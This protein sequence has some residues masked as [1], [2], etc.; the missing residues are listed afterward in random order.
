M[1]Q[2]FNEGEDLGGHFERSLKNGT[3][4]SNCGRIQEDMTGM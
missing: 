4:A 2:R 3:R 1:R